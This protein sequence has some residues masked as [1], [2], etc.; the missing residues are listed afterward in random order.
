MAQKGSDAFNRST[1]GNTWTVTAG[2]LGILEPCDG[3]Q[4]SVH[5]LLTWRKHGKSSVSRCDTEQH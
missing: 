1:L 4:F 5:R 2:S 3:W